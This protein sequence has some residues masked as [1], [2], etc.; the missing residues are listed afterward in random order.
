MNQSDNHYHY[1]LEEQIIFSPMIY[2]SLRIVK[3]TAG[4]FYEKVF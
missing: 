2:R 1:N 4:G 3:K